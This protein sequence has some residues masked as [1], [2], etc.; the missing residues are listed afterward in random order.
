MASSNITMAATYTLSV[1]LLCVAAALVYFSLKIYEASQTIPALLEGI[2]T[3]AAK[4]EPMVN[5]IN[6]IRELVPPILEEVKQTRLMAPAILKEAA[7][8]RETVP[9]ILQQV[10][11]TTQKIPIIL[12]EL[13]ATRAVIPHITKSLH[14]T[15]DAIVM[16]STEMTATRKYLPEL[17]GQIEKTRD[18]IPPILDDAERIVGKAQQTG[19][20]ATEGA[21]TGAL[22]GIFSA[23]FKAVGNI[24]KSVYTSM[25]LNVKEFSAKDRDM[26]KKMSLELLN[27]GIE[28]DIKAWTNPKN[29]N[30]LMISY[31][32]PYSENDRHCKILKYEIGKSNMK[33]VSKNICL[34]KNSE[35]EVQN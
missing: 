2:E 7:S 26:L 21:V 17:M 15:S 35:W 5:E 4:I 25:N 14:T 13:N 28:G 1:S 3:T 23:P 12:R 20:K 22:L 19:K 27:S 6:G 34:D 8:I 30:K 31:V 18:A 16:A 9:P 32:K 24:G 29:G 33:I 10:D 11:K